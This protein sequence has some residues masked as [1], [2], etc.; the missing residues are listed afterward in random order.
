MT[1]TTTPATQELKDGN[2]SDKTFSFAF[3]NSFEEDDV[4]VYV[5]NTTTSVWD[6]KTKDTDYTQT[7]SQ[8]TFTTAPATGSE[9][10]LITRKTDVVDPK[11]DYIAGSS[12]R[13]QDLDNNQRQ[14]IQRLQELENSSLSNTAAKLQGNLDLND[15]NII[16]DGNAV[17][18]LRVGA[19][20]PTNPVNGTRWF[21]TESGRTFI[22][23]TDE[24]SS[25]WVD[26]T[27]TYV[28]VG[29]SDEAL[30]LAG[31]TMTG[32]L[33][34]SGAPTNSLHAATK[35][36]V[37]ANSGAGVTDGDKGDI[38]VTSSG[39]TWS[40]E[41]NAVDQAA[42]ADNA[43]GLDELAGIA[44]GKI[45]YGD[46]NGN[47]AVL[48]P[49]SNGQVLK[50]DGT[51]ISW[52]AVSGSGTVTS[53]AAGTGLTGGTITGS[54]TLAVDVGTSASKIVQLDGSAKLPAV[55]GS[56]LTNVST[57]VADNSV[58][59]AKIALGSDAQGDEMYY[60]G[61]D[62]A[63]LAAGTSGH[64]LKTQGSS[65]NP[66]W[67]S[68]SAGNTFT[69]SYDSSTG[70]VT[71]RTVDAKLED[72]LSVKDFGATGDGLTDDTTAVQ[73]AIDN[74]NNK[75]VYFPKGNYRITS[76]LVI[77]GTRE[78]IRGE[79]P[80]SVISLDV[81]SNTNQQTS[82]IK[83]TGV[84]A[85]TST[86][87][88]RIEN[89]HIKRGTLSGSDW[90]YTNA[91]PFPTSPGANDAAVQVVGS[92]YT[93]PGGI[94]RAMIKDLRIGAFSTGI[95]FNNVVGVSVKNCMVQ[96]YTEYAR[97]NS[98]TGN[99]SKYCIGYHLDGGTTAIGPNHPMSP[100]ASIEL[101]ECDA[102][103]TGVSKYDSN[104]NDT[105]SYGFY[106]KGTDLRDI[107]IRS[108]E[109][110]KGK[111]GIYANSTD[112]TDANWNIQIQRPIIDGSETTA[113]HLENLGGNGA[114]TVNGG[115]L[116][117]DND[118]IYVKSSKGVVITGGVQLLKAGTGGTGVRL[119]NS[120]HCSIIGNRFSNIPS[121]IGLETATYC[122]VTGNVVSVA[123][124]DIIAA[125]TLSSQSG[126]KL[127]SSSSN[128]I[129]G[130][131]IFSG[132]SNSN[133]YGSIFNLAS[134]CNNNRFDSNK[135]EFAGTRVDNGTNNKFGNASLSDIP[136][137]FSGTL[138]TGNNFYTFTDDTNSG[139]SRDSEDQISLKIN[140]NQ[141]FMMKRGG[142]NLN[143]EWC[144]FNTTDNMTNNAHVMHHFNGA[145]AVKSGSGTNISITDSNKEERGKI[146]IGGSSGNV[147]FASSSDY[148]L[149]ENQLPIVGALKQ[150]AQLKPYTFNW[151]ADPRIRVSGFFAHEA[152]EVLPE[153]VDGEKDGTDMQSVDYSKFVPLLTAAVQELTARIEA[154]EG[155]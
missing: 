36:Y 53:V 118:C 117:S 46:A 116:V 5:W 55:D 147:L 96:Q 31:G 29:T 64:F 28:Q 141:G 136:A 27:P 145:I 76:S 153:A 111:Y 129:V 144:Y 73:N 3:T 137:A 114:T 120:D 122:T 39:A 108:C 135:G 4:L 109:T 51:D 155:N 84:D 134:G 13:A 22:Y 41:D 95:Y 68:A 60:N 49:G 21:D 132:E 78:G 89:L 34:L 115:Y 44:R 24:D 91:P 82:A 17:G 154:L 1:V 67:A 124:S 92:P 138:P 40:I 66:V 127:T 107:F 121:P 56:N 26:T 71:N 98:V 99:S 119:N 52:G 130:S 128:N 123:A 20:A 143:H 77:N 94:I 72:F 65:A 126:I 8:I 139:L 110:S 81:T 80:Y 2:G 102:D 148:R 131:N 85:G 19:T 149:K 101:E 38:V 70:V 47:P 146:G 58:T 103:M 63:R 97:T 79:G 106:C 83:L 104:T 105:Q 62:W 75:P 140:G 100:L 87:Y 32:A 150:V 151:I 43:V 74:N 7:G 86:E 142:A 14:V 54:G 152:Q 25:G 10:I 42:L 93:G 61:T 59:G 50:S 48:A 23:Y 37:D 12:V 125:P 112:T 57:T 18:N 11:V 113:I 33:T 45:I 88:T 30:P 69:A 90:T 16:Q 133:Q 6:L 15:F 9:N 35:A